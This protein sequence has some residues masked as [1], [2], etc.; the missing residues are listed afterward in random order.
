[1]NIG[2]LMILCN[3]H[4]ILNKCDLFYRKY[5][6]GWSSDPG[7]DSQLEYR[8]SIFH[9]TKDDSGIFTCMTPARQSHH[10]EIIVDGK[11]QVL[12]LLKIEEQ[13]E[14]IHLDIS[15]VHCPPLPL[16]K[17]L[18]SSSQSTKMSSEV[19]FSCA[20]GN[21]LIGAAQVVCLPSGNWSAPLPLC[22]SEY[23]ISLNYYKIY[24][25]ASY[26]LSVC[27]SVCDNTHCGKYIIYS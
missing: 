26:V 22:E 18:I 27:V 3:Y 23:C 16:R 7:R 12:F 19:M 8:L 9:A 1:M 14:N 10:V 21:S 13:F 2:M 5:P 20:N 11:Y 25:V 4:Q 6:E 24:I 15:A 17:G